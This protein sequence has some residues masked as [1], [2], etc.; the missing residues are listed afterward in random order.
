[1]HQKCLEFAFVRTKLI[2]FEGMAGNCTVT[3]Q[4]KINMNYSRLY[5]LAVF[6]H[7]NYHYQYQLK[8]AACTTNFPGKLKLFDQLHKRMRKFLRAD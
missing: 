1:V 2:P 7:S 5:A 6:T 4:R 8:L 3:M